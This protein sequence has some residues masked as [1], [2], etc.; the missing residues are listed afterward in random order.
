[1]EGLSF[2]FARPPEPWRPSKGEGKAK[3]GL[4]DASLKSCQPLEN[5]FPIIPLI[6]RQNIPKKAKSS[7]H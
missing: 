7:I 2:A 1:L 3:R 5:I 6:L 4:A